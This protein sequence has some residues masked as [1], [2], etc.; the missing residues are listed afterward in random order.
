[1]RSLAWEDLNQ[2]RKDLLDAAAAAMHRAYSPY[3]GFCVG[4]ALLC[5]DGQTVCAAN[6]ENVAYGSTICAERLALGRANAEGRRR[7]LAVAVIARG[8]DFETSQVTAPCGA[9][10]QMLFEAAQVAEVDLEVIMSTTRKDR[11]VLSR[12]SELLPLGF[13]PRD[14]GIDL[15]RYR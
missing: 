5:E 3:S 9:C 6:L 7:L 13:G 1:M 4:A 14:L 12:I 2:R 15:T 8:R 11:I 10:R